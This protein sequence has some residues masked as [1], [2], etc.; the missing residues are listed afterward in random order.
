MSLRKRVPLLLTTGFWNGDRQSSSGHIS[1]PGGSDS[2]CFQSSGS[3][4]HKGRI[5]GG[6]S[7]S[8]ACRLDPFGGCPECATTPV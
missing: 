2:I 3:P 1:D 6:P 7:R 5:R 8:C 4:T